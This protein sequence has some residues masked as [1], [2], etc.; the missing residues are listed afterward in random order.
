MARIIADSRVSYR[1][2]ALIGA[3]L[4]GLALVSGGMADAPKPAAAPPATPHAVNDLLVARPFHLDNGYQNDW[5][6]ERATVRDGY[7]IVLAVERE[8]VHPRQT[9]EPILYVG[10]QTAERLNIG[11]DSG[12]VVA[13]VPAPIDLA[14]APIWFGTPGLP[15][16]VDAAKI[17]DQRR[18]AEQAGIRPIAGA[19]VD[20]ALKS[21]GARLT[22]LDKNDLLRQIVPLV[23]TFAPTEHELAQSMA[24]QPV[25]AAK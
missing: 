12:H 23:R 5:R 15:E 17:T 14:T 4:V 20:A 21:G 7:V 19:K 11:Y 24:L 10:N 1:G 13:L 9:A 8:L 18:T 6:K 16:Q 3:L 22:A 2:T 25:G